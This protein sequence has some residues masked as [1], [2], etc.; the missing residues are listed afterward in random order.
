MKF[1]Y[2]LPLRS[3][4]PNP[5]V[6]SADALGRLAATAEQA[7]FAAVALTEHPAPD[8]AWRIQPGGHDAL[9]PFVGL[10]VCAAATRRVRLLTYLAVLPYRNPFLLA[11][12]AA[13]L[14]VLSGGRL[15]LGLGVGYLEREFAALGVDFAKRNA[16]FDEGLAALKLALSGEVVSC[17][18]SNFSARE[19]RLL[20]AP[21]Q[22][23]HPPLWIG[24]NSKASLT[25]VAT[26]AQGW[27]AMPSTAAQA[28]HRRS[29]ELGP[30]SVGEKIRQMRDQAAVHGRRE[31][32]SICYPLNR[33]ENGFGAN[34]ELARRLAGQGVDW[35]SWTSQATSLAAMCDEVRRFGDAV[36]ADL[37]EKAA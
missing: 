23:P 2:T 15:I 37:R 11:K 21:L 3:V 35:C 25:R 27:M 4:P 34:H 1:V 14:D 18:G 22:K 10:A 31:P 7:G 30:D 19:V 29:A 13:S 12:T 5:E 20:P 16:L 28:K 26:Q 17:E 9:D 8:E 36:P 6:L 33:D 32:L 24:G